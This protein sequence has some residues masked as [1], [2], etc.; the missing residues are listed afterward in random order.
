M[1]D[2]LNQRTVPFFVWANYD[3]E[4][5]NVEYTSL[6]FLSNYIYGAAGLELPA[7]NQFLQEVQEVVPAVS[8]YGYYS[9]EKGMLDKKENMSE[10]EKEIMDQYMLLQYNGMFDYENANETFFPLQEVI[11]AE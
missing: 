5:E 3:I 9:A 11:E 6:N 7:Y 1:Q 4:E 2:E 10:E 8:S